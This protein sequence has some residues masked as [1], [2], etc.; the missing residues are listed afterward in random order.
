MNLRT[1][2][3]YLFRKSDFLRHTSFIKDTANH[4]ATEKVK[5]INEN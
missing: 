3:H 5:N 4:E 2:K 1:L